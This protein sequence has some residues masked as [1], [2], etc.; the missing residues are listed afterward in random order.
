MVCHLLIYL[1][2]GLST[3]DVDAM[4]GGQVQS[5]SIAVIY[6]SDNAGD[7]DFFSITFYCSKKSIYLMQQ[8]AL[9]TVTQ[10][11]KTMG[12]ID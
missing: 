12:F 2:S 9:P 5:F 4:A 8:Q 3:I 1:I 6:S 7:E 10:P 11:L